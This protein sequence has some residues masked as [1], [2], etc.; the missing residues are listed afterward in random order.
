MFEEK[1]LGFGNHRYL[2]NFYPVEIEFEGKSYA[3]VEHAYQSAKTLDEE[4]KEFIRKSSSPAVAKKRGKEVNI[5]HDWDDVKISVM[6][7]LLMLKFNQPYFSERLIGTG[8]AYIEETNWWEDETR[9]FFLKTSQPNPQPEDWSPAKTGALTNAN[10][11]INII[12]FM[13]GFPFRLRL[14]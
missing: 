6:R 3:S 1:I 11:T 2:S 8:D 10:T 14:L 12:C 5:R 13:R 4:Q 9:E 7:E